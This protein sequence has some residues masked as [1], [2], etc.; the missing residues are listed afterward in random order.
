M[1]EPGRGG[2]LVSRVARQL[3]AL[4][5]EA[6]DGDFI[7]AEDELLNRLGISRPTLR[8]AAKIAE[9]EGMISVRR[10]LRGGFYAARPR[11]AD[12]IRALNRYLRLQGA[13]IRDLTMTN[14]VTLE[15]AHAAASCT[16]AALRATLTGLVEEARGCATAR[17]MMDIDTRFARTLAAM[18]GNPVIEVMVAMSYSFG[19]EE[20]GVYLYVDEDQR[21][22]ARGWFAAIADAVISGDGELARF[23][24]QRRLNTVLEW[25]DQADDARFGPVGEL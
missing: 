8:Q 23:M 20:Q 13:T 5:V 2:T 11:V 22:L 9:S 1:S 10:G 7:G 21:E 6:A 4:S 17:G 3:S 16:D 15:S 25:I 18:S 19:L 12:A 14:A 24:M